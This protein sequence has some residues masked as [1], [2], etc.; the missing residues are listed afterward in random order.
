VSGRVSLRATWLS[1]AIGVTGIAALFCARYTVGLFLSRQQCDQRTFHGSL[2][3]NSYL[4]TQVTPVF[5]AAASVFFALTWKRNG[6][7]I[8]AGRLAFLLASLICIN[9]LANL[10]LTFTDGVFFMSCSWEDWND[11]EES[12]LFVILPAFVVSAIFACVI[13]LA[14][15]FRRMNPQPR[16]KM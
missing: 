9:H 15:L 10:N 14:F 8:N 7:A 11:L 5:I 6:L 3:T 2:W 13:G 1:V 12:Y 4:L 16:P